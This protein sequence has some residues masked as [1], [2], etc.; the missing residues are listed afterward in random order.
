MPWG[1]TEGNVSDD[2]QRGLAAAQTE[3]R[4]RSQVVYRMVNNRILDVNDAFGEWDHAEFL[5]ECGVPGCETKVEVSEREYSAIRARTTHFLT[6]VGHFAPGVDQVVSR[7]ERYWIVETLPG[8]PTR[9][10][11]ESAESI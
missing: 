4:A 3:R 11:E 6:A 8:E 5:C 10:A 9:I 1:G 7:R 2:G